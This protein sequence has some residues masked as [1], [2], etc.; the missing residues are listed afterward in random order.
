MMRRYVITLTVLSTVLVRS[1]FGENGLQSSNLLNPNISVIG[2]F[3]GEAGGRRLDQGQEAPPAFDMKEIELGFQSVVDPF[4]RADIFVSVT[5]EG[6]ELEEGFL[7]W[8]HLPHDLAFKVGKFRP[9]FG[10]FNRAHTPETSFADR[11][12]VHERF[13]GSEGLAGVGADLSW[14]VPNPWLLMTL[15]GE[16]LNIP[17]PQEIPAFDTA[18][19]R[20]LLYVG[21]A[22]V[23]KDFTDSANMTLGGS[24][25]QAHSSQTLSSQLV[26]L[27]ITVRW[28]NPRRS[29]Y[30]S[31][32][33]QTEVMGGRREISGKSPVESVGLFSHVEYQ[34]ARRWRAG[35]RFDDTQLP[36]EG[37]KHERGGLGYLTFM[38][39]EFNLIS[40]QGRQAKRFDGTRETLG[41]I[42]VTFN[43]GP[44]GAHPF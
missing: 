23:Y 38:P 43:I 16:I 5:R 19:S 14:Q 44:H 18:S 9:N 34:F 1:G 41:F 4:S 8:F 20:D 36:H 2:W 40:L 35:V 31:A 24:Y 26:G 32:F 13:F 12:L 30:R 33:W 15:D 25:A 21:H 29:I 7:T 28:K 3:Q 37:E 27:D 22:T 42:K 10:K 11:P 6:V 17:S 39:S